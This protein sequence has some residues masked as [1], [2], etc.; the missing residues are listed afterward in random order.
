M[1]KQVIQPKNVYKPAAPYSPIVK[2]T[3][4]GNL[5][6]MAGIAPGDID[7]KL[8]CRGD[9]LGQTR[10][11]VNNIK[12]SLE[13]AGA[14][15]ASIVMTTTYVVDSAMEDFFKTGAAFECLNSLSNPPDT[16]IGVACLA[17][18]RDGQLIEITAVA[19]AE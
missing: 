4:A 16:L 18:S 15:T 1:K 7:G 13:A 11:V 6:F 2:I 14:S 3:G 9:I 12:G 17:G 8:V 19:A 10:Q 5:I